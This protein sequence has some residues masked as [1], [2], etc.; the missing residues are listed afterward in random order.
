MAD[1]NTL[2][3]ATVL[4]DEY[5]IVSVL[6]AGGFG[7]TYLA[8]HLHDK[9]LVAIK[10][11]FP[12]AWCSRDHTGLVSPTS[13]GDQEQFD[14]GLRRFLEEAQRLAKFDH[15]NIMRAERYFSVN[16][17]AYMVLSYEEGQT[18]GGWLQDRASQPDQSELDAIVT[19]LL[20]ALELLHGAGVL[21]VAG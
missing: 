14:W 20:S 5:E 2:P 17:T 6:G 7:I 18:L 12:R 11:Y 13:S 19:P 16:G 10:E 9:N 3:N 8:R 4:F 15:P 1:V 21:T